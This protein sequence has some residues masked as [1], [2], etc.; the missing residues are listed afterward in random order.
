MEQ[1]SHAAEQRAAV[2]DLLLELSANEAFSSGFGQAFVTLPCTNQTF[3]VSDALFHDWLR[4]R[5]YRRTGHPI[6]SRDLGRILA[7]LRSTARC[8][9]RRFLVGLRAFGDDSS[10]S[11]DLNNKESEFVAIT[12]DGW[13][14]TQ[15][16]GIIFRSTR[17]QLPLPHP[18]AESQ[19]SR[20]LEFLNSSPAIHEWLLSALNPSGPY[21]IL[22]LHGPP[23]SG[24]TTLAKML[25]SLLDPVT[26]PLLPLPSRER[27]I[28]KLATRHRV[29][30]FDHVTHMSPTATDALCRISSGT[31]VEL[32][33]PSEGP[34]PVQVEIAR[35]III[36]TPRNGIGDWIPRA[37]LASRAITV[38]MPKIENPRPL[39]A[40][41]S[42]FEASLP[43]LL[44]TLYTTLSSHLA[45]GNAPR[46]T[47]HELRPTMYESSAHADPLFPAIQ[48]LAESTSEWT[49][50][51]TDLLN[52]ICVTAQ[53]TCTS[54]RALS[55][56]L[57]LLTPALSSSGI[58]ITHHHKHGGARLITL[59]RSSP[60]KQTTPGGVPS[61][62]PSGSNMSK[63]ATSE[64]NVGQ[65]LS[66]RPIFNRPC[67]AGC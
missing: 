41:Q 48:S 43:H 47:N 35:P 21:P 14:I 36:T 51:A 38:H 46:T 10:I 40:L 56:R 57:N 42:E 28:S 32:D 2:A 8:N 24:K 18:K 17:G 53:V 26:A 62:V 65:A 66:L 29:L 45:A 63:E 12:K 39:A 5:F 44:A 15:R 1:K 20:I 19:N 16:P 37:D 13:E 33:E 49:G 64:P 50:T 9:P 11:I 34:D 55:Q 7:T 27:A 59:R 54:P 25:R 61:Y 3:A 58:E 31:G 52:E 22:I 30:A 67:G 4:N 23:S 60:P 6:N